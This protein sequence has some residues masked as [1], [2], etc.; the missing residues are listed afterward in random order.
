MPYRQEEPITHQFEPHRTNTPRYR[1]SPRP[2]SCSQ[3]I[4]TVLCVLNSQPF[5][6]TP[7]VP[8]S[9][10]TPSLLL[11]WP[12]PTVPIGRPVP[13]AQPIPIVLIEHKKELDRANPNLVDQEPTQSESL[14]DDNSELTECCIEEVYKANLTLVEKYEGENFGEYDIAIDS[15]LPEE[16]L[17]EDQVIEPSSEIQEQP[18]ISE[19]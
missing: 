2:A 17:R 16:T 12:N 6:T 1:T 10:P 4:P 3:S 19:N 15:T 13:I 7:V 18:K 5:L 8:K 9:Q 11:V 14:K